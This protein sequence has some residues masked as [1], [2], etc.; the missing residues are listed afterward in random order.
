MNSWTINTSLVT[1]ILY[2]LFRK[3]R[4]NKR[5]WRLVSTLGTVQWGKNRIGSYQ[6][7][8]LEQFRRK[9]QSSTA[10][11]STPYLALCWWLVVSIWTRLM[12][13]PL[14]N[15]LY[16]PGVCWL[17]CGYD[18]MVLKSDFVLGVWLYIH[19]CIYIY[20]YIYLCRTKRLSRLTKSLSIVTAA[21][22]WCSAD[23][24]RISCFNYFFHIHCGQLTLFLSFSPQ[25]LLQIS[26]EQWPKHANQISYTPHTPRTTERELVSVE[27]PDVQEVT[28]LSEST[29]SWWRDKHSVNERSI[30]DGSST[31]KNWKTKKVHPRNTK[32]WVLVIVLVLSEEK[33]FTP[34]ILFLL[35]IATS[36]PNLDHC[37]LLGSE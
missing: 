27:W 15:L 12:G 30:W 6:W 28:D 29:E 22:S 16:L 36:R 2:Y 34:D 18:S 25:I 21:H 11:S 14:L 19:I 23:A 9:Q 31:A 17:A 37:V 20:I 24:S 35:A 7:E 26:Q 10:N 3:V 1:N 8:Q 32:F 4:M 33:T 13:E 5:P